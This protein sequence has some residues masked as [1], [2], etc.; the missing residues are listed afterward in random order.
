L[1]A[2]TDSEAAATQKLKDIQQSSQGSKHSTDDNY[3]YEHNLHEK[4][5]QFHII[6]QSIGDAVIATDV[7]GK[8]TLMNP[9]AEQLTGWTIKEAAGKPI[10]EVFKIINEHTRKPAKIPVTEVLKNG[11]IIGLANHTV[12]IAK[13]GTE[14]PI[15]DSAAPIC[16][17][18]GKTIGVVMAF[19]DQTA[20]RNANKLLTD[21]EERYRTLFENVPVGFALHEMIYDENGKAVDYRYLQ[22][23]PAFEDLTG[24]KADS[25]IGKTV[26]EALP[27]TEDYWIEA[28]EK[29]VNTGRTI[30]YDNYSSELKRYYSVRAFRTAPN[31]FAVTFSD[32]TGQKQLEKQL[33]QTQFA[34]DNLADVVIWS[35]IEGQIV[36]VNDIV[37]E[38]YGYSKQELLS[39]HIYDLD[40]ENNYENWDS[41]WNE[42]KTKKYVKLERIHCKKDGTTFPTEVTK[43]FLDFEDSQLICSIIRDITTQKELQQT[44]E[45]RILT[46]TSP[47]EDINNITFEELFNIADIQKT[48][49]NFAAAMNLASIIVSPDGTPIT[50]PSNYPYLCTMILEHQSLSLVE[51]YKINFSQIQ[52]EEFTDDSYIYIC[53]KTGLWEL[54]ANI[55]AG[56]KHIASW[57]FGQIRNDAQTEE[58]MLCKAR[59]IGIDE[60]SFL[61][62]FKKVPVISENQLHKINKALCDLTKQLSSSALQ[63]I[64]QARF[65]AD[66]NNRT[67]ELRRLSAAIEQFSDTVVI[68]DSEGTIEYVNPAFEKITGYSKQEA[69][70]ENPR[71]LKSDKHDAEFYENMWNVITSKK[72]WEGRLI[73]KRKNGELYTEWAT[74]SPVL[75]SNMYITNFV[76]IKRDITDEIAYETKIQHAEKM[77][78]VGQLAGGIA[79]DFNNIMHVIIGFSELLMIE[80]DHDEVAK[81]S[82][83]E[84]QKAAGHAFDLTKQLLLFSRD[85]KVHTSDIDINATVK[86][87]EKIIKSAVGENIKI[88]TTLDPGLYVVKADK[89]QIDR[90]IIN[91]AINARDAMPNGGVINIATHNVEFT[92]GDALA[93]PTIHAGSYVCMSITDTGTGMKD[94]IITHIFEP[95]FT[96]KG[97]SKGTGLGL[98]STYATIQRYN[99]WI[100]TYSEVDKGTTF[101]IYIP[102][103][104]KK[105][106]S[107]TVEGTSKEVNKIGNGEHILV[108]E[109]DPSI[110]SLMTTALENAGYRVKTAH[111]AEL[112]EEIFKEN[113]G[114]FDLL[115]SDVILPGRS[116]PDL[117]EIVAKQKPNLPILL[118]SG[119][120]EERIKKSSLNKKGFHFLE[121]PFSLVKFTKKVNDILRKI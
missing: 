20:E 92:T 14:T 52:P 47:K 53:P 7:D 99:G 59:N 90:I 16:D 104:E 118:C 79:H 44:I 4:E 66:E 67:K 106:Q 56:D 111:D 84:I 32:I 3:R 107:M 68:T 105:V 96:T 22:V 25:L 49:D 8:I 33:K 30:L 108:V 110:L 114:D 69:I 28:F 29:V 87:T 82:L 72:T 40:N 70:G 74:I 121:K 80:I 58:Q 91:M 46:L 24:L 73:N 112:A 57:L 11:K 42:L 19:G 100:N 60:E 35:N 102:A 45:N 2:L 94:E 41:I 81:S 117:A 64:Q 76:A 83:D 55:Y 9:I 62:E 17:E 23:N 88:N 89:Q 39:M 77:E 6:L 98:A 34:V 51:S 38:L 93:N 97:R 86:G 54:S 43:N 5:E 1:K 26:K 37:S 115:I 113:K 27:G 75:D 78:A 10:D 61:K 109:D 119:Y 85:E 31:H 21:S 63:N 95:F 36:Y 65:I 120:S 50:K 103:C 18:K 116:G 101:K 15:A 12:L 48:Q 13:D 71:V